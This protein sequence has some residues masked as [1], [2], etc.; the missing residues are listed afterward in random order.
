VLLC[1]LGRETEEN[2]K[3]EEEEELLRERDRGKR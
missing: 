3:T 2:I 1:S